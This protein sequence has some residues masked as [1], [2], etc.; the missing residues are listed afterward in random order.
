MR[1]CVRGGGGS[2]SYLCRIPLCSCCLVIT[3]GLSPFQREKQCQRR[4]KNI[5]IS[6]IVLLILVGNDAV[7]SIKG[8]INKMS[9]SDNDNN[10]NDDIKR[11]LVMIFPE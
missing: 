7:H 11:R 4:K 10:G 2:D 8:K 3:C 1:V 9:T 5:Q 6:T